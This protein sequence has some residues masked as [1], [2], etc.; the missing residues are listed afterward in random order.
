[1]AWI[2]VVAL[3]ALLLGVWMLRRRRAEQARQRAVDEWRARQPPIVEPVPAKLDEFQRALPS[4][5]R[6]AVLLR[7]DPSQPSGPAGTRLG[8]PVWLPTGTAWPTGNDGRPLEF[9]AQVDFSA[10][11]ALPDFPTA[12]LIQLFIGRDDVYGADFDWPARGNFR[13]LFHPDGATGDG[14]MHAPP[15]LAQDGDADEDGYCCTPF[16]ENAVRETGVPLVG[17]AAEI[18]PQP[19]DWPVD[20]LCRTLGIDSRA[21][22]VAPVLEAMES[23]GPFGH[24]VGGHP[25][26]TQWDYRHV[27]EGESVEPGK[28]GSTAFADLDVLL[29]QLTSDNGLCWGDVGEANVMIRRQDLLERRFERAIW[30]WDCS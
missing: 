29:L 20:Q 5:A 6:P 8:G 24:H 26:F 30:W 16:S 19:Y 3:A 4:L 7:A 13:L 10:L 28:V 9:I 18:P 22:S 2:L 27:R 17:K 21:D 11:P 15:R 12:G 25:A 14:S 1:M 23:A